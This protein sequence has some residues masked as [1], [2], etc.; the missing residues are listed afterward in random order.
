M[1]KRFL[2]PLCLLL[3]LLLS[4]A[5]G[6][7]TVS[8]QAAYSMAGLGFQFD[9]ADTML[10]PEDYTG[11]VLQL[12]DTLTDS[13][14]LPAESITVGEDGLCT[15]SLSE[16]NARA[17]LDNAELLSLGP[18]GAVLWVAE[19]DPARLPWQSEGSDSPLTWQRLMFVQRGKT[20]TPLLQAVSRGV[21]D[22]YGSLKDTLEYK[23]NVS[24]YVIYNYALW[25]PDG[26]YVFQNEWD[27]WFTRG[28]FDDPYLA[29]TVTGEIFLLDA[30]VRK[31]LTDDSYDGPRHLVLCGCFSDESFYYVCLSN[32]S[33][34]TKSFL[35]RYDLQSGETETCYE[36]T[37]MVYSIFGMGENR[38]VML[39]KA[40]N[41]WLN[42]IFLSLTDQGYTADREQLPESVSSST[43]Y[44]ASDDMCILCVDTPT[45]AVASFLLPV[46]WNQLGPWM[47][48]WN[49][50]AEGLCSITADERLADLETFRKKLMNEEIMVVTGSFPDIGHVISIS[51][52]N[53]TPLALIQADISTSVSANWPGRQEC[54]RAIWLLDTETMEARVVYRY[55]RS[56]S[57]YTAGFEPFIYGDIIL[58]GGYPVMLQPTEASEEK[59]G[60][61]V[62]SD[63]EYMVQQIE[64]LLQ[65]RPVLQGSAFCSLEYTD[66][67]TTVTP[68]GNGWQ[69]R[70]VFTR[71]PEPELVT[72]MVPEALTEKRYE[73]IKS[74]LSSKDK[75]K[76]TSYVLISLN[77]ISNQE[78][79]DNLLFCYPGLASEN[80]Y[81][82]KTNITRSAL[83]SLEQLFAKAGYTEEDYR[84]DMENVAVSRGTAS[85]QIQDRDAPRA[86]ET[87]YVNFPGGAL[88]DS[89]SRSRML[90]LCNLCDRFNSAVYL[91][92]LRPSGESEQ[93][94]GLIPETCDVDDTV[95]HITL[96]SVEESDNELILTLTVVP[97]DLR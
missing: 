29:D 24:P 13:L 87:I 30:T 79:A 35:I 50:S 32:E 91:R 15:V 19:I 83:E 88:D 75:K 62:T 10:I 16:D 59:S 26:R 3:C 96:D 25:S 76:L 37:G 48:I 68:S 60:Y 74:R 4:A 2:V 28:D 21:P 33:E 18:D 46:R 12:S 73:E 56:L 23:L 40:S 80:L 66:L 27:R 58:Y 34:E 11:Y 78:E 20:L 9:L 22:K 93:V 72:Y 49:A 39:N 51:S 81:L 57:T 47:K 90:Q 41:G 54:L 8:L 71:Y 70:S 65:V 36:T 55:P 63:G 42:L 69:I 38:W 1:M 77:S 84:I 86:H 17:L 5:A 43:L 61:W 7:E 44:P 92:H 97:Q 6:E 67:S 14:A 82:L 85:V 64:D 45:R 89:L 94:S 95:W 31:R 52:V 53:G